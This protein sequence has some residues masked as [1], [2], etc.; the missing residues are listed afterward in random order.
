MTE[1]TDTNPS[2]S[3]E[4]HTDSSNRLP[5]KT[6]A[7]LE[8]LIENYHA[9]A[10]WIRF[11]DAKAAVV[12]TVGGALAGFLIPSVKHIADSASDTQHEL[13]YWH[14]ISVILFV[15]YI[16]FFA[17]SSAS[18]FLCINPLRNRNGHPSLG[19]CDLFHPVA[20]ANRYRPD[21]VEKFIRDC[22]EAGEDEARQQV[23][24]AIL[25]DSHISSVKYE[26]VRMSIKLFAISIIFGFAYFLV[27]QF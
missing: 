24:A 23:H 1:T 18:A 11:A 15:C 19:Y 2:P 25:L 6:Q 13:P 27:A 12:L 8:Y 22:T 4:S 5:S 7:S 17:L 3:N 21:E 14:L 16:V 9:I 20:I 10:E 26:R